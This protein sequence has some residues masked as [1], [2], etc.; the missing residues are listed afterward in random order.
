MI[1][2]IKSWFNPVMNVVDTLPLHLKVHC[3]MMFMLILS[4][5][6]QA[7]T[8]SFTNILECTEMGDYGSPQVLKVYC[9]DYLFVPNNSSVRRNTDI[10]AA[11]NDGEIEDLS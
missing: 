11:L 5:V 6:G 10:L 7:I 4:S 1:S 9:L 3:S 2:L 8:A